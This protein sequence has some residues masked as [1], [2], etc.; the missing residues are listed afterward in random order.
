MK[1]SK[2]T[3]LWRITGLGLNGISYILGTM[4]LKPTVNNQKSVSTY[5][6]YIDLCKVFA[7]EF[8]LN[9]ID[10]LL[11]SQ[12]SLLPDNKRLTDYISKKKFDKIEKRLSKSMGMPLQS[13]TRMQPLMITNLIA[14]QLL[15]THQPISM[16]KDLWEI[17]TQKG[18]ELTGIET[19]EEQLQILKRIPI[20]YQVKSLLQISEK[21]GQYKKQLFRLAEVYETGDLQKLQQLSKKGLGGIR[22]FMI[23]ERNHLMAKRIVEKAKEKSIFCAIGAGHLAGKEGVLRLLKQKGLVIKPIKIKL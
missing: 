23:I 11:V 2:Q 12:F 21:L 18:K 15:A 7:S 17:A 1:K 4:H 16:D 19:F 6:N 14:E 3:P 20:E 10:P 22:R 8:P 13:L 9:K 5:S